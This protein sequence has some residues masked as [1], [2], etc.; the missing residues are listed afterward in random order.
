MSGDPRGMRSGQD[1][2][3]RILIPNDT[4]VAS[5]RESERVKTRASLAMSTTFTESGSAA[6]VGADRVTSIDKESMTNGRELGK[7]GLEQGGFSL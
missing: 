3:H 7:N 1:S 6:L 5:V 4:A 2:K